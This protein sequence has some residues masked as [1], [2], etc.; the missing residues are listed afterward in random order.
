MCAYANIKVRVKEWRDQIKS[1]NPS[2]PDRLIAIGIPF[3]LKHGNSCKQEISALTLAGDNEFISS[4][5]LSE[6]LPVIDWYISVL[7][8]RG[9]DGDAFILD[10]SALT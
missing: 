8:S 6:D 4:L 10:E 1:Y 2:V 7:L 3:V 9:I 5:D